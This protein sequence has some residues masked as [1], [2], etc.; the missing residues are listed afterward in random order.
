MAAVTGLVAQGAGP[1]QTLYDR[2]RIEL[3]RRAGEIHRFVSSPLAP[4]SQKPLSSSLEA[5]PPPATSIDLGQPEESDEQWLAR[6]DVEWKRWTEQILMI[7]SVFTHLDR[8]Y[9][10]KNPSLSLIWYVL[11][12]S[13]PAAATADF[14]C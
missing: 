8:T 14:I 7:R 4:S 9:V 2:I 3:E 13:R 6:L 12:H 1:S 5:D 11:G 10:L